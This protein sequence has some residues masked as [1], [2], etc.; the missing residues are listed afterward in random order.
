[1]VEELRIERINELIELK[2]YEELLWTLVRMEPEA[3]VCLGQKDDADISSTLITFYGSYLL[4]CQLQQEDG[5]ARNVSYKIDQSDVLKS[6]TVLKRLQE[7]THAIQQVDYKTVYK[8]KYEMEADNAILNHLYSENVTEFRRKMHSI[9]TRNFSSIK[10]SQLQDYLGITGKP[11]Q[12]TF[13]FIDELSP[14]H[15]ARIEFNETTNICKFST[16]SESEQ[17]ASNNTER[18]NDNDDKRQRIANLVQVSSYLEQK[19]L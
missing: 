3:Y 11:A 7:L 9:I 6:S 12:E 5:E 8:Q 13:A 14:N 2:N 16:S 19:S 15:Q 1:M 18:E 17:N 4:V 10:L